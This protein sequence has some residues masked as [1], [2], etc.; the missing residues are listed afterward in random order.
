LRADNT[1]DVAP[2]RACLEGSSS[3]LAPSFAA[4]PREHAASARGRRV[5]LVDV[6]LA[7]HHRDP[8]GQP[9]PRQQPH[10]QPQAV[11]APQEVQE[12]PHEHRLRQDDGQTAALQGEIIPGVGAGAANNGEEGGGRGFSS[13]WLHDPTFVDV[14]PTPPPRRRRGGVLPGWWVALPHGQGDEDDHPQ[15]ATDGGSAQFG[16]ATAGYEAA[17]GLPEWWIHGE[18]D[19]GAARSSDR[20]DGDAVECGGCEEGRLDEG[21]G[22]FVEWEA[23]ADG[24][25]RAVDNLGRGEDGGGAMVV[26]EEA[27]QENGSNAVIACGE[28]R[29]TAGFPS[30]HD[31]GSI[32]GDGGQARHVVRWAQ[33]FQPQDVVMAR[34]DREVPSARHADMQRRALDTAQEQWGGGTS[35]G[36]RQVEQGAGAGMEGLQRQETG[37]EQ[38]LTLTLEAASNRQGVHTMEHEEG[39]HWWKRQRQQAQAGGAADELAPGNHGWQQQQQEDAEREQQQEQLMRV[40]EQRG[41]L[42]SCVREEVQQEQRGGGDAATVHDSSGNNVLLPSWWVSMPPPQDDST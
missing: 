11:Q 3:A 8:W 40:S 24:G 39:G 37:R 29:D 18:D 23:G 16:G 17:H 10:P 6:T 35:G 15:G 1:A 4:I 33:A 27:E 7:R 13:W 41:R 20:N 5:D 2:S 42:R 36:W 19:D 21:S 34:G 30:W 14:R 12:P 9:Q 26:E 22:E 31:K 32:A 38:Q 28:A 25:A